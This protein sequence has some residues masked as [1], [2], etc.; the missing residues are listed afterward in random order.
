MATTLVMWFC[1]CY[2]VISLIFC[3]HGVDGSLE[4]NITHPKTIKTEYGDI[5]DCVDLYKQPAFQHPLLKNHK[6]KAFPEQ[7]EVSN[8][9]SYGLKEGCPLGTVPIR[10]ITKE[11]QLLAE[12]MFTQQFQPSA[13]TFQNNK[14]QSR[15]SGI[16]AR[17]VY[18]KYGLASAYM[19][20]HNPSVGNGQLSGSVISL[21][22]DVGGFDT[23]RAGW[24]ASDIY[25]GTQK[26]CF[27]TYC[28]GFVQINPKLPLDFIIS[29]LSVTGGAYSYI[30][31]DIELHLDGWYLIHTENNVLIGYWPLALF[32]CLNTGAKVL[33]W[34]GWVSSVTQNL[35][36]M[37]DG[38]H[39]N[40]GSVFR[41]VVS[42]VKPDLLITQS[43]CYK[44]G[45]NPA[46]GSYWGQSFW[47]GGNGGDLRKCPL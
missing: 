35:P 16:V 26:G 28:P 3:L 17:P 30:K 29:Q 32:N 11:E 45:V 41:Q 9:L 37:G 20:T 8:N 6:I 12:D 22:C 38:L 19:S 27:N 14:Q 47:Y 31:L 7:I 15:F 23:I 1:T 5:Y 34:G 44:A 2:V 42:D 10:R 43:N 4:S 46:K 36:M 21:E 33:S 18:R 39:G 13:T 24:M 40:I 25:K